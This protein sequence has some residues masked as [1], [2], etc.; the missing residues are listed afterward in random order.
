MSNKYAAQEFETAQ[1]GFLARRISPADVGKVV[2]LGWLPAGSVVTRSGFAA[3][4]VFNGTTNPLNIGFDQSS[5]GL[6]DDPDAFASALN[7]KTAGTQ[8][9]T[10]TTASPMFKKSTRVTVSLTQTGTTTAG[11]GMVFVEYVFLNPFDL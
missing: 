8:F 5:E 6:T 11:D 1:T 2:E 10:F 4:T 9:G 3:A 7:A